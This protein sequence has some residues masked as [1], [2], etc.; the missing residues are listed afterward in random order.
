MNE[1]LVA[2][3]VLLAGILPCTARCLAGDIVDGLVALELAGVL[4]TAVLLLLAEGFHRQ[5]FVDLALVF[6]VVQFAGSLA[7]VRMLER[8]L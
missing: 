3:T 5:S 4:V 7:F 8:R 2:A 1:W 6:A